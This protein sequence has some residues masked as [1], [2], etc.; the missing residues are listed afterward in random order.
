MILQEMSWEEV[1][2]YLETRDDAVLPVGSTE[3]HGPIGLIGTDALCATAVAEGAAAQAGTIML[4]PVAYTPA[5]FNMAFPGTI[6]VSE[7]TFSALLSDII[8]AL[9]T[10]GFRR[11]YVLNGHG[12]NLAPLRALADTAP[13]SMRIRSWWDYPETNALR[14]SLY[15]EWE[16]MHA[17]PSEIAITQ[18]RHRRIDRAPLPAPRALDAAFRAAH[19]GDRHGPPEEHRAEFPCGRVGSWS[20]LARPEHG[21]DLLSLAIREAAV[22]MQDFARLTGP[23]AG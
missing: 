21:A 14:Q 16:G 7:A 22:D 5:P 20:E 4:P 9:A 23:E 2:A 18:A 6:S 15:G 1:E 19:A 12:A 8:A 3:Q 10:H 11:L 17:T 13:L